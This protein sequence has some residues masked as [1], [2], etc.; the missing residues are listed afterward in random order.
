MYLNKFVSRDPGVSAK[1]VLADSTD[2]EEC[3]QE[4]KPRLGR[5]RGLYGSHEYR[6][7]LP[8]IDRAVVP[9]IQHPRKQKDATFALM[10]TYL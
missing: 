9:N 8:K 3:A 5:P 4:T 6:A 10:D 7:S 1:W 2:E